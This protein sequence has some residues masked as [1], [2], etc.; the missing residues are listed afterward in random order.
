MKD[1][2][3]AL[4][5]KDRSG[6]NFFLKTVIQYKVNNWAFT[7]TPPKATFCLDERG[8]T[9]AMENFE[10]LRQREVDK[11]L[12]ET[13]LIVVPFS[14]RLQRSLSRLQRQATQGEGEETCSRARTLQW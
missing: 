1:E 7:Q 5:E 11:Y 8:L 4:P 13:E 3:K 10:A 12:A 6:Y 14:P 9:I 2:F